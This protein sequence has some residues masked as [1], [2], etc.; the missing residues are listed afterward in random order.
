ML[1]VG[2][3]NYVVNLLLLAG[4]AQLAEWEGKWWKLGL[5]A[6][7]GAGYAAACAVWSWWGA[8]VYRALSFLI[9]VLT[10]YGR[11]WQPG[12]LFVLLNL[13][14]EGIALAEEE[15]RQWV[16]PAAAA[17]VWL[18]GKW[19][20]GGKHLR[21]QIANE[22]L[23]ALRDTGN[24]LRDPVSGEAVLVI[25]AEP[26]YRLTGLTCAQLADPLD[27]LTSVKVPG[28]RVIPYHAVGTQSGFLL[29]KRFEQVKIG[30]R[31]RAAVVAFAP[32]SLGGEA[33]Q[34]LTGRRM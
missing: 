17:G 21:V 12:A 5:S 23:T 33:Y 27:A 6:L 10:A 11:S 24:E 15:G 29:A 32:S 28:L 1:A 25:A 30:S 8:P 20:F 31:R 14:V 3:L 16:A 7:L 4:A 9:M 22:V 26:A 2:M 34:A 18:L 19:A 13:A